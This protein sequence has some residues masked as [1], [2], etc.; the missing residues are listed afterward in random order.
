MGYRI[1]NNLCAHCGH[2]FTANRPEAKYCP[3][4]KCRKAAQRARQRAKKTGLDGF[5]PR[6]IADLFAIGQNSEKAA[7]AIMHVRR[8]FGLNAARAALWAAWCTLMLD[9]VADEECPYKSDQHEL[10]LRGVPV[11]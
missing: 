6:E 2:A 11:L 3:G 8:Q 10:A 7:L 1:Y 9:N 4:S 5:T